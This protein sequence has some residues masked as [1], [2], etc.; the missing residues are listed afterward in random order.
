MIIPFPRSFGDYSLG[1]RGAALSLVVAGNSGELGRCAEGLVLRREAVAL[2]VADCT[3]CVSAV[4]SGSGLSSAMP[5][6]LQL[7]RASLQS[8]RVDER[9]AGDSRRVLSSRTI[10]CLLVMWLGVRVAFAR[11]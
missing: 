2:E 8:G 6:P 10:R 3:T 4:H 7:D 5:Q 9:D 11:R 1:E